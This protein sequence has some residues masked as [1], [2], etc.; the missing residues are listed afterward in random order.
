MFKSLPAS[1]KAKHHAD[2]GNSAIDKGLDPF[3]KPVVYQINS[4]MAFLRCRIRKCEKDNN[5]LYQR[6]QFFSAEDALAKNYP[7]QD[8]KRRDKDHEKKSAFGTGIN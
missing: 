5:H 8:I 1:E 6:Y 7:Q 4:N 2:K 3:G